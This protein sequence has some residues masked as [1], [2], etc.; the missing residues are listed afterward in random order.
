VPAEALRQWLL[1]SF[2]HSEVMPRDVV[3]LAPIRSLRESPAARAALAVLVRHGWLVPLGEGAV[4][5]GA[6]RKEAYR[7]VRAGDG[8]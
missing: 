2:P 1:G 4:V 3:R 8:V 6:P 5:R 7:I